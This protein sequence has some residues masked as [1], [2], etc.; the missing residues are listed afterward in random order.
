MLGVVDPET[1]E[2][3]TGLGELKK[4]LGVCMQASLGRCVS[5]ND[6]YEVLRMVQI[7]VQLQTL[8]EEDPNLTTFIQGGVMERCLRFELDFESK[9]VLVSTAKNAGGTTRLKYRSAH[10]PLRFSYGG[11][12]YSSRQ[13]WEGA[14]TLLPEDAALEL[15]YSIAPCSLTVQ[16]RKSWFQAFAV[17]IGA[18]NDPTK[19]A[20]RVLY[21]PGSPKSTAIL[22][23]PDEPSTELGVLRAFDAEYAVLHKNEAAR[24]YGVGFMAKDWTPLRFGPGPS[25]NG[26]FF[27]MKSYER[28]GV[29][30]ETPELILTEETF[31]FL[32]HMPDSPMPDCPSDASLASGSAPK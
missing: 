11:N 9:I 10:V 26:E 8:G 14:C 31:F 16:A 29:I 6:P 1:G 3:E 13:I 30:W 19:S 7:A 2:V 20:V 25:Q 4:L 12:T 28:P 18:L 17:W 15:P 24:V 5:R 27:A 21:Y 22:I 23:C 32:K